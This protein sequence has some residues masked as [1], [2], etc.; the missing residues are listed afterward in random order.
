MRYSFLFFVLIS[1][2]ASSQTA[3]TID[4]SFS[5]LFD[6]LPKLASTV[7][8]AKQVYSSKSTPTSAYEKEIKQQI[9]ILLKASNHQS[10]LL[11]MLAGKFE[12]ERKRYNF[13]KVEITRDASLEVVQKDA[14]A[15]MFNA[16]DYYLRNI[17]WGTDSA[18]KESTG[19]ALSKWLLRI[20]Q[21]EL[22]VLSKKIKKLLMDID[23]TM[24]VK[25]YNKVLATQNDK[26]KYYIHILETKG[27][28]LDWLLRINQ[29][30]DVANKMAAGKF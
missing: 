26:H 20:Y 29:Q 28:M 14:S 11:S 4:T 23:K 10:S 17:H 19:D 9:D 21:Q 18:F 5:S 2:A 13:I 1:C 22:P 3:S 30:V 27:L 7:E 15:N 16:L 12:E 8:E 24:A 6:R 25:G